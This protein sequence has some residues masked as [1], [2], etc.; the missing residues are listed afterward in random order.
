MVLYLFDLD[1]EEEFQTTRESD[2]NLFKGLPHHAEENILVR[3]LMILIV[4]GDHIEIKGPL[5]EEGIKVRMEDHQIEKIIRIEDILKEGIQ[6]KVGDPL[7]EE[8][9]LMMED[10]PIMED[11]LEMDNILDT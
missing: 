6:I 1:P 4:M 5:K 3:V 10:P 8:D 2:K 9:P 11:P 7:N